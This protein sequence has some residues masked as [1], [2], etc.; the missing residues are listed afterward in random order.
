MYL[1]RREDGKYTVYVIKHRQEGGDWEVNMFNTGL[2]DCNQCEE[3]T[4]LSGTFDRQ[5][6]LD[7]LP[8]IQ[9]ANPRLE[10]KVFEVTLTQTTN[11][12]L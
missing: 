2:P 8:S 11:P 10:F 12:V 1:K 9:A 3:L 6:A 7:A 4:G 5:A